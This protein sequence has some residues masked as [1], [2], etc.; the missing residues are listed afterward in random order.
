MPLGPSIYNETEGLPCYSK[1]LSLSFELHGLH[2][3]LQIDMFKRQSYFDLSD[4]NFISL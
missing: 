2:D 3:A 4:T 1:E